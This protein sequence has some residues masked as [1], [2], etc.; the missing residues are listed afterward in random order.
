MAQLGPPYFCFSPVTDTPCVIDQ[1]NGVDL[2]YKTNGF[3]R[4]SNGL[5][6]VF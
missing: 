3:K 1:Y 2:E 4:Q 5:Q 6:M